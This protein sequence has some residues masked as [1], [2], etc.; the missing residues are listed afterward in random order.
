MI[1]QGNYQIKDA[2]SSLVIQLSLDIYARALWEVLTNAHYKSFMVNR[3]M[4]IS[5]V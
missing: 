2:G 1:L 3:W 4:V 5:L